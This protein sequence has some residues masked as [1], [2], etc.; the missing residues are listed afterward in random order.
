MSTNRVSPKAGWVDARQLPRGP[1]GRALCRHCGTE[2]PQGRRTFCGEPC[3]EAWT[4]RTTPTLMRQRVFA[5][6]R[7]VCA[8][9]GIAAEALDQA[10]RAEWRRVKLAT[11]PE[12]ARERAEFRRRYR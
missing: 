9:C 2:V 8:R 12:L 10:L 3:V 1:N 7:G 4:V 11:T 6:D 5:R